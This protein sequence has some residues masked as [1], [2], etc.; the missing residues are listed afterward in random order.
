MLRILATAL[1]VL[2]VFH[3]PVRADQA[4]VIDSCNNPPAQYDLGKAK[5]IYQDKDGNQCFK[6]TVSVSAVA[7][8]AYSSTTA[9]ASNLAI[10]ASANK[11]LAGFQVSVDSTLLQSP[12]WIMIFDATS[13]PADGPLTPPNTSAKCYGVPANTPS[14]SYGFTSPPKFTNGIVITVSTTGCFDKTE[15]AHAFISG[16]IQ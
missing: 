14:R 5:P 2:F 9:I 16:D 3:G 8:T 4:I 10:P 11:S 13:A 1:F 15:S 6:G 7:S 12:W